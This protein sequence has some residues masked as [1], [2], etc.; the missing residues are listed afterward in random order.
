MVKAME[1]H[2]TYWDQTRGK[3]AYFEH[4]RYGDGWH[5]GWC[6]AKDFFAGRVNGLIPI[7]G[8]AAAAAAGPL[9][10]K[11]KEQREQVV[12]ADKIGFLDLW[13][14]KRMREEGRL[15]DRDQEGSE[16]GWEWEHGFRRGV[17]DFEACAGIQGE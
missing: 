15:G 4:W 3:T 5:L 1:E 14:W 13:V 9:C 12:G 17:R 8:D 6:D 11:N 2:E 16:F 7:P 10:P